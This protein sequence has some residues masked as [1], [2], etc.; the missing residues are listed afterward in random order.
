VVSFIL[1]YGAGMDPEEECCLVEPEDV[2]ELCKCDAPCFL[3]VWDHGP[4]DW[5]TDVSTLS[6]PFGQAKTALP[7]ALRFDC[8]K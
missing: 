7:Y 1:S 4:V 2:H 6:G 8:E 5:A 3:V